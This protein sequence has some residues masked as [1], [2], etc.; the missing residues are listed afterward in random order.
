MRKD[1]MLLKKIFFV[2][3]ALVLALCAVGC[4]KEEP[5][6][7][8]EEMQK[9]PEVMTMAGDGWSFEYD[10]LL[11]EDSG[12][13]TASYSGGDSPMPVYLTVQVFP[14]DTAET[15]AQGLRL[16]SGSDSTKIEDAAVGRDGL[17]AKLVYIER[18]VGEISEATQYR[19]FYAIDTQGGCVLIEAGSYD[20]AP[21]AAEEGLEAMLD[22]FALQ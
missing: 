4:G 5:G 8:L 6:I 9:T 3:L 19:R 17:S 10:P 1:V 11:F 22:S 15:V 7:S 13:M 18:T 16:Q 14:G 12:D 20:G 2:T 21:A